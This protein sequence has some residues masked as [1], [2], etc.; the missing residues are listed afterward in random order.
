MPSPMLMD[1]VLVFG[2]SL[3]D[4]GRK[5]KTK[6]GRMATS[7]NQMYVS[8]SGRFSDCRNWTDYMIEAATGKSLVVD[9]AAGTISLS[10]MHTSLSNESLLEGLNS[11]YFANYAEGGACGDKPASMGPFLG[12]F[13]GQV[14]WFEEDLRASSLPLGNTLIFAWFGANDLYT[15]GRKSQEM[16]QVANE[17]AVNQRNRLAEIVRANGGNCRFIFVNLARALTTTR[18]TKQ[19]AE[20]EAAMLKELKIKD[21]RGFNERSRRPNYNF[22]PD[23]WRASNLWHAQQALD[24]AS[25]RNITSGHLSASAR[26]FKNLQEKVTEIKAFEIGVMNYNSQLAINANANFDN[27]AEVGNV[28]SE[29]TIA[30]LFEGNYGLMAGGMKERP[31]HVSSAGY[32]TSA[33]K[34]INTIDEVHPTDHVY[35]LIWGEIYEEVKRSGSTFGNLVGAREFSTLAQ[36]SGPSNAV[37]SEFNTVLEQIRSGQHQLRPLTRPRR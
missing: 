26:A 11:F 4:I 20:L 2:D 19:L 9:S 34:P 25:V 15:A 17:V 29:E 13:K 7:T 14:D 21:F 28:L 12:T 6:A 3:S 27:V 30:R 24:I 22:E 18:Y 32:S 23:S 16:G 36:L 31:G 35:R 5:W 37:H 33:V 8:S 1:T 10:K